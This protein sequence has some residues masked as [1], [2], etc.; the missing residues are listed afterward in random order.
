M[1]KRHVIVVVVWLV[2][3]FVVGHCEGGSRVFRVVKP[4]K[5]DHQKS[6]S[7]PTTV[8]GLLPKAMPI[9]PSAPS[10]DHNDI[11]LHSSTNTFSP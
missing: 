3:M 7:S 2:V 1:G 9:P 11:G 4:S 6:S 5:S 8:V 10:K